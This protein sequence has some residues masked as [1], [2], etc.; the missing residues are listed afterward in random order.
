MRLLD[1]ESAVRVKAVES[2]YR[3]GAPAVPALARALGNA[4]SAVRSDAAYSLGALGQAAGS[5]E[6]ALVDAVIHDTRSVRARAALALGLT[7]VVKEDVLSALVRAV[8]GRRR[9]RSSLCGRCTWF[10][11]PRGQQRGSS[12]LAAMEQR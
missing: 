1:G 11:R 10:D 8:A 9:G 4:D 3:I 5:A 6:P 12:A 2:L 7:G